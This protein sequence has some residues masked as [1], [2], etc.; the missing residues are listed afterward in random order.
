[1]SK[2]YKV[3]ISST[4]EDLIGE[5]GD[6]INTL[7]A[8]GYLPT[9][10]EFF[11]SSPHAPIEEIK[12]RM[13]DCDYYLLIIKE[14][15]GSIYPGTGKSYTEMEYDHAIELGLPPL[16][17]LYKELDERKKKEA[18]SKALPKKLKEFV[19]KVSRHTV[20][21]WTDTPSL[22][23]DIGFS[24]N[25]FV[26]DNPAPGF[27]KSSPDKQVISFDQIDVQEKK[28]AYF[29]FLQLQRGANGQSTAAPFRYIA[30]LEANKRNIPVL[31]ECV[32]YQ[33]NEFAQPVSGFVVSNQSSGT[34][35]MAVLHP[36]QPKLFFPEGVTLTNPQMVEQTLR[37]TANT[38]VTASRFLNA[39]QAN[40]FFR[41]KMEKA[42]K[43]AVLVVD[44]QYLEKAEKCIA[45]AKVKGSLLTKDA[46]GNPVEKSLA[47]SS[48]L[49]QPAGEAEYA[50]MLFWISEKALQKGDF[51]KLDFSAAIDWQVLVGDE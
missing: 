36:W 44:F 14:K 26:R 2:I 16:V 48:S 23:A 17:F 6:I 18:T 5:R 38:L 29:Q 46:E 50:P 24:L 25:N 39:F 43:L 30:R 32:F 34:V 11:G 9:A 47:V 31:D 3:F 51:L 12:K 35:D 33:V 49:Q 20:S 15:Y 42:T 37:G 7:L 19:A 21:H 1:M 40:Q 8:N 28:T 4:Y 45:P 41:T 13:D 27:V 10:M 22:R